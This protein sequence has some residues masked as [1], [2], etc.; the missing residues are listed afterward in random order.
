M[1]KFI[2]ID[3]LGA[4]GKTELAKKI[5]AK[6]GGATIIHTDDFYKPIDQRTVGLV[7]EIISPDFDWDR[8][9]REVLQKKHVGVVIVVGVY[10]L[11]KRFRKYYDFT[12]WVDAPQKIR[13][14]R[15]IKREGEAVAREWQEKWLPREERYL[16]IERPDKWASV[17]LT[18]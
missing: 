3:G 17:I 12:I 4:S 10:A 14:E 5:A 13:I 16:I 8:L 9:E 11:Q 15:M 1:Q 2:G 18:S 7:S 6:L